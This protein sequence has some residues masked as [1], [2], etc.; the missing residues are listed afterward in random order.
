[1]S[2]KLSTKKTSPYFV[3]L[4]R[5]VNWVI[6]DLLEKKRSKPE[7]LVRHFTMFLSSMFDIELHHNGQELVFDLKCFPD[8]YSVGDLQPI[9]SLM[10]LENRTFILNSTFDRINEIKT[11][12]L[13]EFNIDR[14]LLRFGNS[15]HACE[16][17]PEINGWI[18]LRLAELKRSSAVMFGNSIP[19][20][21]RFSCFDDLKNETHTLKIDIPSSHVFSVETINQKA[22]AALE[23]HEGYLMSESVEQLNLWGYHMYS[24]NLVENGPIFLDLSKDVNSE[25]LQFNCL[26]NCLFAHDKTSHII[27]L[28]GKG[29]RFT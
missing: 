23:E 20:V 18:R 16:I 13:A 27:I 6:N 10:T 7:P 1:M 19:V 4:P 5:M 8:Y 14:I 29:V 15:F 24:K 3:N 2:K 28:R 11:A 17:K 21:I 12:L 9:Y 22:A 26:V 25:D